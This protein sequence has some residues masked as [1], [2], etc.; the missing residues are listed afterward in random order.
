MNKVTQKINNKINLYIKKNNFKN[1]LLCVSGGVDSIVLFHSVLNSS[2]DL[3]FSFAICH[4][5]HNVREKSNL[6]ELLC[7]DI[8]KKNNIRIYKGSMSTNFK[9]KINET[10][11]RTE[12]YNYINNIFKNHN[13]DSIF[14]AHH[15][16]DQIETYLMRKSQTN[17]N[18]ILTGI[19]KKYNNL[20]RPFLEISKDEIYT[21]AN[22]NKMVW[23]EDE[24]NKNISYLRNNIRNS[25]IPNLITQDFDFK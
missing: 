18:M 15:V 17:D 25:L 21:Y 14:T 16:D 10:Y 19:R 11:L 13:F 23:Y 4:F 3:N 8:A 1:I 9:S 6:D 20:H 5:N 12:R 24:T 22:F 2:K 7:I